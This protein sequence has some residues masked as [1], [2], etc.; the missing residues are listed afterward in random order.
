MQV[1]LVPT[2]FKEQTPLSTGL[3]T[4]PY[5]CVEFVDVSASDVISVYIHRMRH[6]CVWYQLI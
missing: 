6:L 4:E 1:F 3:F 2:V 5:S